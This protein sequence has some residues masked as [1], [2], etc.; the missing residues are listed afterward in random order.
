M[1]T[2]PVWAQGQSL[3]QNPIEAELLNTSPDRSTE[4]RLLPSTGTLRDEG[5]LLGA[6]DVIQVQIFDV[7]EYSGTYTIQA[8]GSLNLPL[9]GL[10]NVQ[11]LTLVQA[12]A[13]LSQA[14]AP[15]VRRPFV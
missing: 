8:D 1:T 11:G 9:V 14:L 5:Y 7:P 3:A 12:S 13:I 6:G 15:I 10:V 2:L 4:L